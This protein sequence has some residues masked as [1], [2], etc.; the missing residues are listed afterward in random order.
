MLKN[1]L[2]D[3]IAGVLYNIKRIDANIEIIVNGAFFV[4]QDWDFNTIL[5]PDND[6]Q[7]GYIISGLFQRKTILFR[8]KIEDIIA[9]KEEVNNITLYINPD[10]ILIVQKSNT[11]PVIIEKD[12]NKFIGFIKKNKIC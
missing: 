9:Y 12:L 4:N 2:L 1:K 10:I 7:F 3:S 11:L 5:K 6:I 8:F